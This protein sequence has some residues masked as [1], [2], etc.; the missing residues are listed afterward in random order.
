MDKHAQSAALM[1]QSAS[2]FR[3]TLAASTIYQNKR[4]RVKRQQVFTI[5]DLVNVY[6][7]L[8]YA[9]KLI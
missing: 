1:R 8:Q 2:V 9:V 4:I 6:R 3:A 7:T 5:S